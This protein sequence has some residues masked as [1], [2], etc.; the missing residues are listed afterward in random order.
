MLSEF[1]R[2]STQIL[3][4]QFVG[5]TCKPIYSTQY[6]ILVKFQI[7]IYINQALFIFA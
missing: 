6:C 3:M 7:F 4:I 1:T 2:Y 5:E